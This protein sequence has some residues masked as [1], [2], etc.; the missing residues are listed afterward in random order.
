MASFMQIVVI[1]EQARGWLQSNTRISARA[2]KREFDWDDE[3][4]EE[5]I[6]RS[7]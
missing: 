5:R 2:L 1:V 6:E 7:S 3:T 4:L